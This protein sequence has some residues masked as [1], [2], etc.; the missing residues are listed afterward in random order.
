M[1]T[2][3]QRKKYSK[4]KDERKET[5]RE[6]NS[7]RVNVVNFRNIT[8]ISLALIAGISHGLHL[9]NMFEN[10]RF[11][12]HLSPLE[13]ELSFRTEMGL[14]YSYYKT[15]VSSD[16]FS[17]GIEQLLHDNVTEYPDTINTLRRFNLLPEVQLIWR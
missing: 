15:V 5:I 2:V 9:Y 13:R 3:R 8:V 16:S 7:E 14:Y 1:S 6:E 10:D 12:S 17:S 11:F 4:K